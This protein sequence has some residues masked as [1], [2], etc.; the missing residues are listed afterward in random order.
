M[1]NEKKCT[2][3][4]ESDRYYIHIATDGARVPWTLS[5]GFCSPKMISY[6]TS[7][8]NRQTKNRKFAEMLRVLNSCVVFV[9]GGRGDAIE[10]AMCSVRYRLPYNNVL[11]RVVLYIGMR[12]KIQSILN[13]SCIYRYIIL[14]LATCTVTQRT[15]HCRY[16][17]VLGNHNISIRIDMNINWLRISMATVF[18]CSMPIQRGCSQLY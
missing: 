11:V 14:T 6:R 1:I 2:Y 3:R 9:C 16:I 10:L 5:F 4:R 13:V 8:K 17:S 7:T 18:Q 15:L 12:R